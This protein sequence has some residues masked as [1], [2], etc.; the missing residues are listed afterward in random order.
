MS[1]STV[2][3]TNLLSQW[4]VVIIAFSRDET[5]WRLHC[6]KTLLRTNNKKW[7]YFYQNNHGSFKVTSH[8][9]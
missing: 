5:E 4:A 6:I 9:S 2:H 7:T 8:T 1:Q 3:L